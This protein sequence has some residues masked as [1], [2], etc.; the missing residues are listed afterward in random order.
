MLELAK[1]AEAEDDN[2]PLA[3]NTDIK[4]TTTQ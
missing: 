2:N 4:S 3:L 1:K